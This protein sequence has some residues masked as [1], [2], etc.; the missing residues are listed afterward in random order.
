MDGWQLI[1]LKLWIM[2]KRLIILIIVFTFNSSL[3]DNKQ[4][5]KNF[6]VYIF[7]NNIKCL[8]CFTTI[9]EYILDNWETRNFNIHA[10][11]VNDSNT[12]D[13]VGLGFIKSAIYYADS[14]HLWNVKESLEIT[15]MELNIIHSTPCILVKEKNKRIYFNSKMLFEGRTEIS[16]SFKML[17]KSRL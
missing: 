11:Y 9:E 6:D 4:N 8:P 16:D 3:R 12:N 14:F 15:P 17:L 2:I 13:S 7:A 10:C 1:Y 5:S